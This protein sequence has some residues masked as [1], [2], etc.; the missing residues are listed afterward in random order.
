MPPTVHK[1][2]KDEWDTTLHEFNNARG[3][4]SQ[5]RRKFME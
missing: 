2:Y 4:A 5:P 1:T 3:A